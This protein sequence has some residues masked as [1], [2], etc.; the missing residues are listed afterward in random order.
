M[1]EML[2]EDFQRLLSDFDFGAVRKVMCAL[3][4]K[5]H[6]PN[7]S[8]FNERIPTIPEMKIMVSSLFDSIIN[9]GWQNASSGG[10]TLSNIDG[11][12]WLRFIAVESEIIPETSGFGE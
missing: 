8:S 10:F 2:E 4:W 1:R 6:F 12:L 11:C 5:W 9:Q 3:N 7:S